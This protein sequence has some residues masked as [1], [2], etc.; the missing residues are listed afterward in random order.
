MRPALSELVM[1]DTSVLVHLVR[2][3]PTGQAIE[4]DLRLARRAE[5]PLY[6]VVAEGEL[7]G[8]ATYWGWGEPKMVIVDELLRELVVVD[9]GSPDVIAAYAGFYT[10]ATT[11]GLPRGENDLWIAAAAAAS[12]ATLVTCDRDF[13][14]MHPDHLHVHCF[15]GAT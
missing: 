12:S 7:R 8:L 11:R 14:W 2:N 6:C 5:R 4:A 1:L 3:D 9:I 10:I 13:G 15:A